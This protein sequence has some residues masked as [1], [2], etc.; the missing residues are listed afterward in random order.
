M[1]GIFSALAPT[2]NHKRNFKVKVITLCDLI[3]TSE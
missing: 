2:N 1:K 3:H